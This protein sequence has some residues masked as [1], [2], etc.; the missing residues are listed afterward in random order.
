MSRTGKK[1]KV[2]KGGGEKISFSENIYTPDSDPYTN[3]LTRKF[4]KWCLSL[5]SCNVPMFWNLYDREK[6]FP[7]EKRM[8]MLF[9]LFDMRLFTFLFLFYN[10]LAFGFGSSQNIRILSDSDPQHCLY[11]ILYFHF[12]RQEWIG[13]QTRARLADYLKKVPVPHSF[14]SAILKF[15]IHH[16][17]QCCGS[18]MFYPGSG[19]DLCSIPDPDPGS[20]G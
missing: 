15:K 2:R 11:L 19:S 3:I 4:L 17:R 10:S 5:L 20:G 18:E 1:Y 12:Y 14:F 16:Y 9:E 13:W 8:F 7:P 6:G